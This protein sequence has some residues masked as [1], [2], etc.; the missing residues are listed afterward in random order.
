M[1]TQNST[2]IHRVTFGDLAGNIL[3]YSF[4]VIIIPIIGVTKPRP[5]PEFS[6]LASSG[7]V[8]IT[9][10]LSQ[11]HYVSD[12]TRDKVVPDQTPVLVI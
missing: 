7:S 10:R 11:F 6:R 5:G 4:P 12:L 9:D 2:L 1:C 3:Y 8:D